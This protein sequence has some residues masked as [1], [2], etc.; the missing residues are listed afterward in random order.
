M[1]FRSSCLKVFLTN[2][3][4]LYSESRLE[5]QIY[6]VAKNFSLQVKKKKGKKKSRMAIVEV[7]NYQDYQN[8]LKTEFELD[9]VI[10]KI[11]KYLEPDQRMELNESR[12]QLRV[13]FSLI[14]S[15]FSEL[16]AKQIF[17]KFG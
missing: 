4:L 3:P 6:R 9:G 2:I 10:C 13:Y 15:T 5:E 14:A 12:L 11:R 7:F 16:D 17:S 1:D 8:L